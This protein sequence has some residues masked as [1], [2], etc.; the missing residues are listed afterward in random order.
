M[1][2]E[3]PP[4]PVRESRVEYRN[5]FKITCYVLE[6]PDGEL[7]EYRYLHLPSRAG[8]S[9]LAITEA[10]QVVLTRE[11][12]HP[13]GRTIF[14]L[15][16]GGIDDNEQPIAAARRELREETGYAA[17]RI[18]KLGQYYPL[19]AATPF[20]S[21]VFVARELTLGPRELDEQEVVE[22]VLKDWA[23]VVEMVLDGDA[24]GGALVFAVLRRLA[25]PPGGE[26]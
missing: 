19:P 13:I 2:A 15:P 16:G 14:G 9:V 6:K 1:D 25:A 11:Y 12:R 10:N 4:W 5:W 21:H 24:V 26:A 22:V 18:D 17:G 20:T 8:A 3:T 7:M 23:E